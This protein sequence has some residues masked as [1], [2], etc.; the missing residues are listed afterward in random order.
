MG[1]R[2]ISRTYMGEDSKYNYCPHCVKELEV[3]GKNYKEILKPLVRVKTGEPVKRPDG[4]YWE[5]EDE[6]YECSRCGSTRITVDTFRRIYT[7]RAD[8]TKWNEPPKSPSTIW[9]IEK[10]KFVKADWDSVNQKWIENK[11]A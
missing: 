7:V 4:S 2:I 11:N 10:G 9:N 8:G 3:E 6:H 5:Y 1:M